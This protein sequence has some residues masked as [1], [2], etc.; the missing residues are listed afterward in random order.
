VVE[1]FAIALLEGKALLGTGDASIEILRIIP[2]GK[3]EMSGI[4]WLRGLRLIEGESR[5]VGASA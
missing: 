4:E 2:E 1:N 3:R 5:R